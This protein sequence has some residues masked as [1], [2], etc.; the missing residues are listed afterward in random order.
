MLTQMWID[1]D[2]KRHEST[3]NIFQKSNPQSASSISEKESTLAKSKYGWNSKYDGGYFASDF[4]HKCPTRNLIAEVGGIARPKSIRTR[5]TRMTYQAQ[6]SGIISICK[7]IPSAI[8]VRRGWYLSQISLPES[9]FK[10]PMPT[11]TF[12]HPGHQQL[13]PPQTISLSLHPP[14]HILRSVSKSISQP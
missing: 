12:L 13:A 6:E 5:Y 4:R 2:C 10:C 8:V 7:E 9:H 11:P 14:L 1:I 3:A